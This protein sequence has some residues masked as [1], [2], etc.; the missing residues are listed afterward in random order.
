MIK[1]EFINIYIVF[2][3]FKILIMKIIKQLKPYHPEEE[4]LL[5]F[6]EIPFI[7]VIL[8]VSLPIVSMLYFALQV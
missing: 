2:R 5:F 7:S 6:K 4:L 3:K 8:L 1:L